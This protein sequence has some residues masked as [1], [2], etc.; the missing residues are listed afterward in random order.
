M[1]ANKRLALEDEWIL[2]KL[3]NCAAKTN[4]ALE[5]HNFFDATNAIY[6]FWLYDFCDVYLELIKPRMRLDAT[7]PSG[8]VAREVLYICLD[9][10]LRLLHPM[11]PFVS[12]ELYQRLPAAPSKAESI[13]I[14]NYPQQVV[15]WSSALVEDQM[16]IVKTVI[17][18]F[19][20]QMAQI[21]IK[22][23]AK[24]N[25]YVYMSNSDD[26]KL[27]RGAAHHVVNLAKLESLQVLPS[28]DL[29]GLP[30]SLVVSV[31][32]DRCSIY[33]DAAGMV[34]F[35]V[36]IDKLVKK[37]GI[38]EKSLQGIEKKKSMAGYLEKVPIDVRAEND[39]KENAYRTQI[40]EID[41]AVEMLKK[42]GGL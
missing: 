33:I 21:G 2:S 19:R 8:V 32:S 24:P 23:N 17:G 18:A 9:R 22:N 3:S 13:C 12:E 6:S 34:D 25:A 29:T 5:G 35:K 11:M 36:E 1:S 16:E 40:R 7:D 26:Q 14:A 38:V 28:S 39:E 10:G 30:S 31:V 27:I 42:A 15:A 4:N 41:T 20:S 37:R